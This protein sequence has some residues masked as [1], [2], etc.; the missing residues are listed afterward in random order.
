MKIEDSEKEEINCEIDKLIMLVDDLKGT[1]VLLRDNI[2]S[3]YPDEDQIIKLSRSVIGYGRY[4]STE[5]L[6]FHNLDG[7]VIEKDG[8]YRL[9]YTGDIMDLLKESK[10]LAAYTQAIYGKSL[11]EKYKREAER[12]KNGDL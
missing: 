7:A 12:L 1:L 9:L 2:N 8:E 10:A 5:L 11:Y 3:D 6:T 4:S